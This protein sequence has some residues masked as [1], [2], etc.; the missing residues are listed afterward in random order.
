VALVLLVAVV[1]VLR[2][3]GLVRIRLPQNARQ[4]PQEVLRDHLVRGAL[5]FGF[6]L[7]TGVRT[8]VSAGAPYALAAAALLVGQPV[9]A[10][11]LAAVGFGIGRA[12]TPLL[13]CASQAGERW[14]ALMQRRRSTVTVLCSAALA[15]AFGLLLW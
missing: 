9:S 8:Y 7:G 14:D 4:I 3:V 11:A 10:G 6:E 5:Q 13:R 2:D 15:V 1:A 12:L